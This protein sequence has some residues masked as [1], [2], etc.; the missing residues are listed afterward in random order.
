[1]LRPTLIALVPTHFREGLAKAGFFE[2]KTF[3]S[4]NVG[5]SNLF[6]IL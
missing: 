3:A 1:M 6:V 2:G 4:K 5:H